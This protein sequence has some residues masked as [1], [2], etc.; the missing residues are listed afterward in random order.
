MVIIDK[1]DNVLI[2]DKYRACDYLNRLANESE[3]LKIF[4]EALKEELS[5]ANRDNDALEKENEQLKQRIKVLENTIDGLT[6]TIAHFDLDE[7]IGD[8]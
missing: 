6:G 4:L 5:L 2:R 8:D 7:V 3:Q 1:K